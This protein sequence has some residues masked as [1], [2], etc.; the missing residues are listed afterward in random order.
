MEDKTMKVFTVHM[1]PVFLGKDL[2]A[3][4]L[5]VDHQYFVVVVEQAV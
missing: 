5:Q 4:L 1:D 2:M 3:D